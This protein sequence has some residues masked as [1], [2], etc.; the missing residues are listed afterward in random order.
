M[1]EIMAQG[2]NDS[3]I[4]GNTSA[5]FTHDFDDKLIV[6]RMIREILL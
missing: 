5:K 4:Y 1:S 3:E 6:R 2:G